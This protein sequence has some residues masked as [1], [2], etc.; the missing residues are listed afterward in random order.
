[1]VRTGNSYTKAYTKEYNCIMGGEYSGHIYFR[2]KFLGFD[3]GIYAGLRTLEL[4]SETD[5]KLSELADSLNQYI[6]TPELK[7]ASS[8]DTKF[9]VVSKI[10]T[11]A[12]KKRYNFLEIDGIRVT[13]DDGWVSVRASNTGGNITMRVEAKTKEKCDELQ[14][15]FETKL[16]EIL[17]KTK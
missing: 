14:K 8:D 13:F 5:Q 2:D 15:E 3:S 10:K 7:F 12:K 16:K 6:S 9:K 17:T 1:M 11:Y 4:L